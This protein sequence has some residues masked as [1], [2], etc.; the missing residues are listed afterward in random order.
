MKLQE[1]ALCLGMLIA[2]L[3]T[4][5]ASAQNSQPA[6]AQIKVLQVHRSVLA[7]HLCQEL[8]RDASVEY[9]ID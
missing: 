5:S 1:E 6:Q 8:M 7:N 4:T 9:G 2:L 3:L